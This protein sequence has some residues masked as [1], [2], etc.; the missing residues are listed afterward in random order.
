MAKI[1]QTYYSI[2]ILE[3]A[4]KWLCEQRKNAPD[5]HS[6]WALR[7]NWETRRPEIARQLQA[8]TYTFSPIHCVPIENDPAGKGVRFCWEAED[9]LVQKCIAI[10]LTLL[11]ADFIAPTC[12][13]F[14]GRGGLKKAVSDVQGALKTHPFFYRTDVKSY[15]QSINL[16]IL[17]RQ[18]KPVVKDPALRRILWRFLHHVLTHGGDFADNTQGLPMGS[19]LSP[20]FSALYLRPLDEAMAK[21]NIIYCRYQDD[22]ILLSKTRWPLERAKVRLYAMLEN[23]QLELRPEKTFV[24][25]LG[26]KPLEF[27]GFQFTTDTLSTSSVTQARCV[28]KI[29]G[30]CK[31]KR[32]HRVILTYMSRWCRWASAGLE[33]VNLPAWMVGLCRWLELFVRLFELRFYLL[34]LRQ[35][36]RFI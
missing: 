26:N 33:G 34:R 27:L 32:P 4:F 22:I 25:R 31:K 21:E 14:K 12:M 5:S 8:G 24:G 28:Q 10:F 29:R 11:L 35:R 18:I 16:Q 15:Y 13:H 36:K 19:P 30:L 1:R 23:L 3:A 17:W 20:L 9:S 6:I 2:H 7:A